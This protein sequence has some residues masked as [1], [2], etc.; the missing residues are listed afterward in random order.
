[1]LLTIVVISIV[2]VWCVPAMA[3]SYSGKIDLV[4]VSSQGTRLFIR[5]Q[6]LSLWATSADVRDILIQGFFKKSS[7]TIAYTVKTCPAGITGKCGDIVTVLVDTAGF[8]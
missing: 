7:L 3:D 1:M 4:Q 8:L 2:A 5:A 6:Q